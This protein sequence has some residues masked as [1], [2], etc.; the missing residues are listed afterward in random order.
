[1][2]PARRSSL[3]ATRIRPGVAGGDG[4]TARHRQRRLGHRAGTLVQMGQGIGVVAGIRA[5]RHGALE[6]RG[7]LRRPAQLDQGVAQLVVGLGA[8]RRQP[9]RL[10]I[11]RDRLLEPAQGL[12]RPA[13]VVVR[14]GQGGIEPGGAVV[15]G[16]RIA[17][18][19]G[20][21]EQHAQVT[22]VGRDIRPRRHCRLDRA[23]RLVGAA[24]LLRGDAEQVQGGRMVRPRRQSP[25]V[26]RLRQGEPA[27]TVVA[28]TLG[29]PCAGGIRLDP[30]DG[31][32]GLGGPSPLRP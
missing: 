31:S 17:R 7:G 13:A 28:Q 9:Q 4:Q 29:Q 14:G 15:G 6:F 23:D 5:Q 18:P 12:E 30:A 8:A 3:A 2:R 25:P 22:L 27:G 24:G 11:G 1:M 26:Q 16:Q 21:L 10:A 20:L 32:A 19:P